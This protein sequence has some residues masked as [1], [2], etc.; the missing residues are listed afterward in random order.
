M[1]QSVTENIS[2]DP[3]Q[4][5][6]ILDS[7]LLIDCLY[8]LAN[9]KIPWMNPQNHHHMLSKVGKSLKSLTGQSTKLVIR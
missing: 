6:I 1:L 7:M 2:D 5:P 3:N 9:K 4:R 8:Y